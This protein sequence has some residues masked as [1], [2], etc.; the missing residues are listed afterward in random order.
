M[1]RHFNWIRPLRMT[2]PFLFVA[3]QI[4]LGVLL[5]TLP[6]RLENILSFVSVIHACLFCLLWIA[7]TR[8]YILTQ[9]ALLGTVGADYF[10]ILHQ[11]Q[12]KLPAMLFFLATQLLYAARLWY[13]EDRPAGRRWHIPLRMLLS[14][15]I[16]VV[17]L[18]V[19]Q[20]HTDALAL[21]SMLY[22]VNLILNLLFACLRFRDNPLLA[23][24]FLL[25]LL[26]DTVVGLDM[27]NTYLP[28]PADSPMYAI[29]HPGFNLAWV[30]YLP[31]QTL[32]ALSLLPFHH[33]RSAPKKSQNENL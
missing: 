3:I 21:V 25:F 2:A 29:L 33:K 1:S 8:A 22:Y 26:C 17:T 12:L 24:G 15:I 18:A 27:L 11:P 6:G 16:V 13:E 32:L 4:T 7:P 19:L 28:I 9:A 10:L 30:F 31:S 14:A 23:V 20:E 5:Q